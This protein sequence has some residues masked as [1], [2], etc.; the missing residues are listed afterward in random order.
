MNENAIGAARCE[1]RVVGTSTS[2][3]D[4]EVWHIPAEFLGAKSPEKVQI[5]PAQGN[6]S[7]Y[8]NYVEPT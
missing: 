2:Q 8:Q 1:R 4:L 5:C 7:L 6:F 3:K